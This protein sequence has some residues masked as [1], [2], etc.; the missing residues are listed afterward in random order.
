MVTLTVNLGNNE[1]HSFEFDNIRELVK[2][3]PFL[4]GKFSHLV[5]EFTGRPKHV[6]YVWTPDGE[7]HRVYGLQ[8][9]AEMVSCSIT[10]ITNGF[11]RARLLPEHIAG[12][13]CPAA[14][15]KGC[16]ITRVEEFERAVAEA[17]NIRD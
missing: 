13:A 9:V 1:T 2:G 15:V 12:V 6:F 4:R 11:Y 7:R 3:S 14:C 8:A 17:P 5:D 16:W 10:S